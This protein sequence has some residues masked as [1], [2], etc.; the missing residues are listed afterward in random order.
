MLLEQR[1]VIPGCGKRSEQK[2]NL[3]K[4]VQLALKRQT[5][6]KLTQYDTHLQIPNPIYLDCWSEK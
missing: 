2:A 5:E 3:N 4:Q 6:P 1:L